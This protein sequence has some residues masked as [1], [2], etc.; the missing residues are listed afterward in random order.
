MGKYELTRSVWLRTK[1]QFSQADCA[2]I[3]D[4]VF[5]A[6]FNELEAH[7]RVNI[8]HFGTFYVEERTGRVYHDR[9]NNKTVEVPTQFYPKFRAA[10]RLKEF[11]GKTVSFR[12]REL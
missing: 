11:V 12:N 10:E 8:A 3:I 2:Q 5:D 9:F 6:I 4:A 7:G 1:K